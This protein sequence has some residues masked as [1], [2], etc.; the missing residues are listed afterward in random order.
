M[1]AAK[2]RMG[3]NLYLDHDYLFVGYGSD[4]HQGWAVDFRTG[5]VL[6]GDPTLGMSNIGQLAK[7][8]PVPTKS[9]PIRAWQLWA[10]RCRKMISEEIKS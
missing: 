10:A 8:P 2:F 4:G 6:Y 7:V 5:V 1:T 9:Q 3:E